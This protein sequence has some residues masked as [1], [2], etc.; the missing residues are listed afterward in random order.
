MAGMSEV[1]ELSLMKVAANGGG[2]GD[3]G[4][5]RPGGNGYGSSSSLA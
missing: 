4:K 2:W 5:G 1:Q 3:E